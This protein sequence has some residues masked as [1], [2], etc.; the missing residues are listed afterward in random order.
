MSTT[1][2][3]TTS[4][5]QPFT[6]TLSTSHFP[7]FTFTPSPTKPSS[8]PSSR[9]ATIPTCPASTPSRH[10]NQKDISKSQSSGTINREKTMSMDRDR[11]SIDTFTSV[12]ERDTVYSR[13]STVAAILRSL[14]S[15]TSER[16]QGIN[17]LC[18]YIEGKKGKGKNEEEIRKK[19]NVLESMVSADLGEIFV[20]ASLR[21]G[22]ARKT[23]H[24]PPPFIPPAEES[25]RPDNSPITYTSPSFTFS[26]SPVS[27]SSSFATESGSISISNF[28]YNPSTSSIT[29]SSSSSPPPLTSSSSPHTSIP[30]TP[31]SPFARAHTLTSSSTSSASSLGRA[32]T[33]LSPLAIGGWGRSW[34]RPLLRSNDDDRKSSSRQKMVFDGISLKNFPNPPDHIPSPSSPGPDEA[35][36]ID[37]RSEKHIFTREFLDSNRISRFFHVDIDDTTHDLSPTKSTSHTLDQSWLSLSISDVDD[38]SS[39]GLPSAGLPDST[40]TS[41]SSETGSGA[42]EWDRIIQ[43]Q[44]AMG[45]GMGLDDE[46]TVTGIE[47]SRWSA[48]ISNVEEIA[49]SQDRSELDKG[50]TEASLLRDAY[51]SMINTPPLIKIPGP[52][53]GD[54]HTI[55]MAYAQPAAA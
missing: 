39:V 47:S 32:P 28:G 52:E 14:G 30:F 6:L 51:L 42:F 15:S 53:Q 44:S 16:E 19:L 21:S 31:Y 13:A 12:I 50:P 3:T 25:P 55:L 29:P 36:K 35:G 24:P 11:L 10:I 17:A 38:K 22:L 20:K 26:F 45:V 43:S 5:N 2:T 8:S 1:T 37:T 9:W 41:T 46:R 33:L 34:E 7:P 4:Q 40:P 18:G 54:S 49:S 48:V 27:S 23:T